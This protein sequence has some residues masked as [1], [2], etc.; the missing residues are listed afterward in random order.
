[1]SAV[2]RI[3]PVPSLAAVLLLL[4]PLAGAHLTNPSGSATSAALTGDGCRW[5]GAVPASGSCTDLD[6]GVSGTYVGAAGAVLVSDRFPLSI[7]P[8]LGIC[9]E[10][11]CSTNGYEIPLDHHLDTPTL[12]CPDG[13]CYSL[14]AEC[15]LEVMDSGA[16]NDPLK[17]LDESKVDGGNG[18]GGNNGG[19]IPDGTWDD[20]GLGA[21]CHIKDYLEAD[22]STLGCAGTSHAEDAV[23][24]AGVWIVPACDDTSWVSGLG[25]PYCV[26]HETVFGQDLS[27]CASVLGSS[28]N[29]LLSGT[30]GAGGFQACG[31]DGA[32]D[33]ANLGLGGGA[34]GAGV[35]YPADR[36]SCDALATGVTFVM[37]AA[38]A[39]GSTVTPTPAVAGWIDWNYGSGSTFVAGPGTTIDLCPTPVGAV[40][41][42]VPP[43]VGPLC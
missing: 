2:H 33:E 26:A 19:S 36:A 34:G 29:C 31:A 12:S 20:G 28:V 41:A 25:L 37:V 27:V 43:P 32:T 13:R 14:Y 16:P 39:I 7:V 35:A 5:G 22:Y 38:E 3:P 24:G 6:N 11:Y 42:L 18:A 30:C 21:A 10:G 17:P 8:F 4:T 23:A 1:V 15:D 9:Q 40:L